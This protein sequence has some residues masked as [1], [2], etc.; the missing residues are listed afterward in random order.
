M[1]NLV[2]LYRKEILWWV[3]VAMTLIS[4]ILYIKDMIRGS[5]KPHIF[6]W[7]LRWIL[8]GIWFWA[9]YLDG[10]WPW[11]WVLLA[12]AVSCVTVIILWA[13]QWLWYITLSDKI[14]FL[15]ALL[16]IGIRYI[17]NDP[18]W[19]IIVIILIDTR[20]YFPTFRKW[21]ISPYEEHVLARF[22]SWLK[23]IFAF[24]A[25]DHISLITVLYPASIFILNISLVIMLEIRRDK[26]A[27]RG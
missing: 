3:A 9:A 5:T 24:F 2:T 18:L 7:I 14:S 12:S 10:G 25:L 1:N 11:T 17:T 15:W 6:S 13:K 23:Y 19:S 4:E 16:S 21:Y 26:L 20:S 27:S 8:S 22:F